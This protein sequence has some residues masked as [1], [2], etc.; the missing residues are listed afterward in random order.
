MY[1]VQQLVAGLLQLYGLVLLGRVLSTW[2][3]PEGRHPV[4]RFLFRLT[5]PVLAP[6]RRILPRTGPF[7][8]A[9]VIV[10]VLLEVLARVIL[11]L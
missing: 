6:I 8:L 11:A 7:D 2:V 3:D 5:E 9:P 1:V 10:F 4:S